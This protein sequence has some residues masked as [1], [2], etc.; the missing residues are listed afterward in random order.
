MPIAPDMVL[1]GIRRAIGSPNE[2]VALHEPQF[3]GREWE[4]VKECIDTGW[5]SSVGRFVDRFEAE[6]AQTC[7]VEHAV[8]VVNGTAALHAALLVLGVRPGEEVIVPALTFVATANAVAHCGAVPHF[9]DSEEA[10]LGIDPA[11]LDRHLADIVRKNGSGCVNGATGRRIAAIVPMHVFG[12][13]VD[14]D[15][16]DA[17]A[18][19]YGLPV[20]EDATEAIGSAYKGR[21]LGSFGALSTLSFNGNKTVT[22]G[23]GGAILTNDPDIASRAKHLTTTGKRPH[24]WAFE[25]D[26]VAY[27]YRLPNINAALGVAQL[28]RLDGF[29]A[30][31][32]RLA[33]RYE[34]AFAGVGGLRFFKEQPFARSNYWLNAIVLDEA[35]ASERDDIL[36]VTNRAGLMTRPVWQLMHRLPMYR[37]CPRMDLAVAESLERRIINLPSSAKLGDEPA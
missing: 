1:S 37:D 26:C 28:E 36:A 10:T 34:Q 33:A 12:H 3:S 24:A 21:K 2:P 6:L 9:A 25:H 22:T 11:K 32:R 18:A 23:G 17:V 7:G 15:P 13:P 30:S 29:L 35:S 4:Y 19:R 31:K 14:M 8:A 20:L 5:V 16:L 27:N